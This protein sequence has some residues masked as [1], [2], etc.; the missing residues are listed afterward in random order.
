MYTIQFTLSNL[1]TT[2]DLYFKSNK[3]ISNS[4]KNN[5]QNRD[6]FY[7]DIFEMN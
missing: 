2:I 4:K 1:D 3:S 5:K 7:C 6:L